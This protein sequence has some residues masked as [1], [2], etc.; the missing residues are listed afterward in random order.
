MHIAYAEIIAKN[1]VPW[2]RLLTNLGLTAHGLVEGEGR[3]STVLQAG[4]V[5]ILVSVP[6][7]DSPA[8]RWLAHHGD[9]VADVAFAVSDVPAAFTHAVAAGAEPVTWPERVFPPDGAGVS[10]RAVVRVAGS[11][12]HTLLAAPRPTPARLPTPPTSPTPRNP[13]AAATPPTPSTAPPALAPDGGYT[14][15]DH[16]AIC[17]PARELEAVA[18][19]YCQAFGMFWTPT[20]TVVVDDQGM[21]SGFLQTRGCTITIVTPAPAR[22]PGQVDAFLKLHGGTGVQHVAFGHTDVVAAVRHASARG[23]PFLPAPDAYFDQLPARLGGVPP[24]LDGLRATGVLAD[25]DEL[26][27]LRQI[28]TAPPGP[29]TPVFLELIQRDG[30]AGFG[31]GNIAALYE[32]KRQF[33][34]RGTL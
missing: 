9:G 32:A 18:E 5:Q 26:G 15:V 2:V 7:K 34:E 17:V 28:F 3:L 11:L 1:N 14:G 20:E 30:A 16:I 25:R 10:G 27:W 29:W 19:L 8:G 6:V 4:P 21:N 33:E 12:R 31:L 23:A 22:A 24:D 13:P